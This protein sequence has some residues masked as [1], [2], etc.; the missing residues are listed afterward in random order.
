[1]KLSVDATDLLKYV[2]NLQKMPAEM[3]ARIVKALNETGDGLT[4]ELVEDLSTETGLPIEAVRGLVE[5][6]RANRSKLEY[7]ITMKVGSLEDEMETRPMLGR[8][9]P[10]RDVTGFHDE[11]LVTVITAQDDKVCPACKEIAANGPY[12]IEQVR[13]DPRYKIKH[14]PECRCAVVPYHSRRRLEVKAEP[15]AD[16]QSGVGR[17]EKIR[18]TIGGL[19]KRLLAE[20]AQKV[21]LKVVR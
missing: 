11:Q 13:Y 8:E 4:R 15:F 10:T 7:D 18:T 21:S 19:A 20:A 14:H 2:G 16:T 6:R 3:D 9:F 5:V 1:M 12:T 17:S